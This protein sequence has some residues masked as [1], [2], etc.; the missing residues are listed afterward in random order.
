MLFIN[1]CLA[2]SRNANIHYLDSLNEENMETTPIVY[3]PGAFGYA[4]QFSDEMV[5]LSKRRCIALSLRGRGKSE[6]PLS[7]YSF[8]HHVSDIDAVV[9]Q[10]CIKNF[11]LMA[12][13]MGVPYALKYAIDNPSVI[14]GLILCDY[15]AKYPKLTNT[16]S[17]NAISKGLISKEREYVITEIQK[18]SSEISLWNQIQ[19][20]QCPVL[21]LQGG[22]DKAMLKNDEAEKYKNHLENIK[23]VTFSDSGHELWIPSYDQFMATIDDFL[24]L[25]DR[26]TLLS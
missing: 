14:R 8:E 5:V 6:A 18:E 9:K 23:I 13:S 19:R 25:L 4:E 24:T 1:D 12:Y 7:G 22:T 10:S 17:D 21:V 20:I 11:C 16:W 26:Q 3:V 2:S 15:P